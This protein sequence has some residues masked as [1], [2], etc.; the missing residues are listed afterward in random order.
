MISFKRPSYFCGKL[1]IVEPFS[2]FQLARIQ[3]DSVVE[4]LKELHPD[5]H[6]EI[7]KRSLPSMQNSCWLFVIEFSMGDMVNIHSP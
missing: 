1:S 4:K 7:C 3:T 2:P 6:F 5:V